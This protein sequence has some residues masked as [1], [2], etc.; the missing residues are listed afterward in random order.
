MDESSTTHMHILMPIVEEEFTGPLRDLL[1]L[2][3]NVHIRVASHCTVDLVDGP[4]IRANF[5]I[6]RPD[7]RSRGSLKVA[8]LSVGVEDL[9]FDDEQL[10]RA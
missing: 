1:T 9:R 7:Q 10:E 2:L 5:R 3:D 8:L 4:R 6:Y